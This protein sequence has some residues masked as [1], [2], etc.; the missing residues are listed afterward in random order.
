MVNFPVCT[1]ERIRSS[2]IMSGNISED[3]KDAKR[4]DPI[5]GLGRVG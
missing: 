2:I 5:N 4:P 3:Q 1:V